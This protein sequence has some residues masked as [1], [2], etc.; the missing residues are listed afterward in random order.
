MRENT[1]MSDLISV[2]IPVY[3]VEQY[4]DRCVESVVAQK[5]G[6]LEIILVDDGSPD[7]CPQICEEWANRD[8]R[9][10]VIHK[11]NGGL[12]DARNVGIANSCGKYLVFVD[13]D[14]YIDNRFV[15][16]LYNQI[17]DNCAQIS[18]VDMLMFGDMDSVNPDVSVHETEIYNGREAL[19]ASYVPSKFQNFMC[20]KMF[21]RTLFDIIKFPKGKVMEDLAVA[22]KLFDQCSR[23]SYCPVKLYYYYQREG[24]LLHNTNV[25]YLRD[26]FFFSKEKY[27]YVKRKYPDMIEN[28]QHFNLVVLE[29]YASLNSDEKKYA[30]Q[31]FAQNRKY[32]LIDNN[33]KNKTKFILFLLSKKLYCVTWKFLKK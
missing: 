22:Y 8:A 15:E 5:Y 3:K 4:L 33:W 13:S 20:N 7:C 24:S 25:N 29:S 31:E 17:V 23:V 9:I 32:G 2:I 26:W 6:N 27:M 21:D 11:T 16:C 18:C 10:K 1:S 28:Y 19:A 12:S 30:R 14:D